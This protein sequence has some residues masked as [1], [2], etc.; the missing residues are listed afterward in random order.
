MKNENFWGEG[1]LFP[2]IKEKLP[3]R[4]YKKY[5]NIRP[6]NFHFLNYKKT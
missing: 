4:K 5:L 1:F 6:V 2:K 3:L